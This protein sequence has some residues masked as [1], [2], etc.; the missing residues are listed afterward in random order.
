M[1]DKRQIIRN[2]PTAIIQVLG[3]FQRIAARLI[4]TAKEK[5]QDREGYGVGSV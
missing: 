3:H 2:P 1:F 4:A 5:K